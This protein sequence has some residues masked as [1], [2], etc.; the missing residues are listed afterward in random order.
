M[1]LSPCA[2]EAELMTR[3]GGPTDVR[4][5]RLGFPINLTFAQNARRPRSPACSPI[6]SPVLR[7][8]PG[9]SP[10]T[11]ARTARMSSS[12]RLT[13]VILKPRAQAQRL[14]RLPATAEPEGDALLHVRNAKYLHGGMA[15]ETVNSG[16]NVLIWPLQ[17]QAG[18]ND[19]HT[20]CA[21]SWSH[22]AMCALSNE[23]VFAE[24]CAFS[25]LHFALGLVSFDT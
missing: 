15:S 22:R 12:L 11:T 20:I 4:I 14:L 23:Q 9:V 1:R 5:D 17:A 10:S 6:S 24:L 16:S 19:G 13:V 25:R 3:S 7:L 18:L 21:H 8:R 2:N